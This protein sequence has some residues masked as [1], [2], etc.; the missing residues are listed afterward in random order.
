[1]NRVATDLTGDMGAGHGYSLITDV[2]TPVT[3]SYPFVHNVPGPRDAVD[4]EYDGPAH[5][6]EAAQRAC[7]G[8]KTRGNDMFPVATLLPWYQ[9]LIGNSSHRMP[10]LKTIPAQAYRRLCVQKR[11]CVYGTQ[12]ATLPRRSAASH[13]LDK[14]KKEPALYSALHYQPPR[15]SV[16]PDASI[17]AS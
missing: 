4:K 15:Q 13:L 12:L 8:V 10:C 2:R 14:K 5:C 11:P 9:D 7:P 1:M 3:H 16:T 17:D 6:A